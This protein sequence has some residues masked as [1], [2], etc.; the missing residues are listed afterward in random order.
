MNICVL[1]KKHVT[2]LLNVK[3]LF[4][5]CTNETCPWCTAHPPFFPLPTPHLK[6]GS[7][8]NLFV[9][10]KA[11]KSSSILASHQPTTLPR[12]LS[13]KSPTTVS[14]FYTST[15]TPCYSLFLLLFYFHYYCCYCS[16]SSSTPCYSLSF[17]YCS[18]STTTVVTVLPLVVHHTTAS[19]SVTVL[20]LLLHHAT[21][22]PLLLYHLH[23]TRNYPATTL[24]VFLLFH[25]LHHCF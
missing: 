25:I 7:V 24:P 16:T 9:A 20:P 23:S 12:K 22:S 18:T 8:A 17:C 11:L 3:S 2:A 5:T 6:L 10:K 21:A 13:D 15:T 19:L 1:H 14:L 4:G